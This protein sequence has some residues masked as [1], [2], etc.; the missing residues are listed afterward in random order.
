M[1]VR[2]LPGLAAELRAYKRRAVKE[3]RSRAAR[4]EAAMPAAV[5]L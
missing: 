3:A 5:L 4:A 1:A 2:A